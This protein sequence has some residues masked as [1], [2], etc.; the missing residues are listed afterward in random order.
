MYSHIFLSNSLSETKS[1]EAKQPVSI[2][3]LFFQGSGSREDE[4]RLQREGALA[5]HDAGSRLNALVALSCFSRLEL[6]R[7]SN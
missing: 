4:V 6:R 3:L 7:T 2:I 5:L 1:D